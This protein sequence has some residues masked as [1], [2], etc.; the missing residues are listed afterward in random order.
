MTK[1]NTKKTFDVRI[2]YVEDDKEIR[3]SVSEML[4]RR[5]KKLF[6]ANDGMEGL[7]IY[8]KYQPEIIITDIKMP[9][10]N[11]LE[12]AREIKD[13]NNNAQVII[14]SAHS[15]V[16][17]FT[18]SIEIGINQY[19]LKPISSKKLFEAVDKCYHTIELQKKVEYQNQHIEKLSHTVEQSPSV[20]VITDTS[21][22]IEYVNPR[23][24]QVTGYSKEEVTNKKSNILKANQNNPEVFKDIIEKIKDGKEWRGEY[25]NKRKDG[26]SY[27]EYASISPVRDDEGNITSYVKVSE[28]I[29]HIINIENQLKIS[30]KKYKTLIA[31]LDEGI[32]IVDFE[33]NFTFANPALC[34]IFGLDEGESMVGRSLEEFTDKGQLSLIKEQT[35][36]RKKGEKSVYDL[37]IIRKDGKK[38]QI[39]V[40]ASPQAN[41]KGEPIETH[42][43]FQDITERQQLLNQLRMREM[44]YR[45]LVENLGEGIGTVDLNEKFTYANRAAE[46]IFNVSKGQLTG[47]SVR[48]FTTKEQ[49]ELIQKQTEKRKIGNK[50]V[51]EI[52]INWQNGEKRTLIV[53]A[54]P[55]YNAEGKII[56]AQGIFQ[57]ITERIKLIDELRK[58]KDRAENAY[59]I[60]EQ[61]NR[62][63]T[64]SIEYAQDI[65]QAMFPSEEMLEIFFP[66]SFILYK[67]KD[68]VSG[69]F[70]WIYFKDNM[71]FIAAVDCTGHGV[72]GAFMSMLGNGL[73]N[74]AVS[75][76]KLY[77]PADILKDINNGIFKMIQSEGKKNISDGMDIALCT[78]DFVN[79]KLEFSGAFRPLYIFRNKELIQ[80]K[81]DIS[82]IGY[83]YNQNIQNFT[84]HEI[85]FLEGDTVYIFSDG[86]AH[87]NGGPKNKK[88]GTK[89]LKEILHNIQ[90]LSM[91]EQ[92]RALEEEWEKW[93]GEQEQLDDVIMIGIKL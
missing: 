89:R 26:T 78:I 63:I 17:Y 85:D 49:Y 54:T 41:E 28:D 9:A 14:S 37:E 71:N 44:K 42:G 84:N 86:Y 2:L 87:Q 74:Q 24:T 69:D 61:K 76:H 30:E 77:R 72:P 82:P 70:P 21:G 48:D 51:Y 73:L 80:I 45:S 4:A 7:E 64:D 88:L 55:Q 75:E 6:I 13:I 47:K 25:L 33:E 5:V 39:I 62:K 60:I 36:K 52:E 8:K 35:K 66:D 22:F 3:T 68:I 81:G 27:W 92:K 38:R 15:D 53:T 34:K 50:D 67:T 12:M 65:Q 11:G 18:E 40:T 91:S 16:N 29:T 20:I 93:K 79:K 19:L 57:D 31:N 32:G 1:K 59:Q 83:Y 23:F 90:E 46:E 58:A 43:I 10:M 56:G